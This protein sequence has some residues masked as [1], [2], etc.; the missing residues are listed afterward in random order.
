MDSL[1]VFGS[2][3]G[4]TLGGPRLASDIDDAIPRSYGLTANFPKRPRAAKA[5][6]NPEALFGALPKTPTRAPVLWAHQ[7]DQLRSYFNQHGD[8]PDVALELPTGSGKT[9]V[10]LLIADWRRRAKDHRTVYAC[11][12]VQLAEQVHKSA[13]QQGIETTLLVGTRSQWDSA[14]LASYT[15]AVSVVVTTYSHV[16]N[17]YSAFSDVQ[18]LVFDDAHAAE[19]YVA[20]SWS[21]TVPRSHALYRML[22]EILRDDV[23]GMFVD[24]MINKTDE[25]PHDPEIRVMPMS[26]LI[27]KRSELVRVLQEAA[28][29]KKETLRYDIL[30]LLPS[31]QSCLFYINQKE[32]YIRPYIPPTFDHAPFVE[33]TQRVYL[34]ATLGNG[35][36]LERA[37]GRPKVARIGVP[38]QWEQ[39]GSG[40]RF[41]VF[42][43]LVEN[44]SFG[45]ARSVEDKAVEGEAE[46]VEPS[47][48]ERILN[49]SDKRVV[50]A[51]DGPT[52]ERVAKVLKVPSDQLFRVSDKQFK[53]F[54]DA[55][56]G[57]LLAANRY[58]GMDLAND[59]C[60]MM[61]M[62]GLPS[63]SHLQ[64]RFLES[65]LRA[66]DVLLE[67]VRTR[68]IQGLGRC[69]RGPQDYSVVVVEGEQL[70][71]FLS[72]RENRSAMPVDLQAEIEYGLYTS[73][74]VDAETLLALT[75]S[76][77]RQ[78]ATWQT[79][80]E[81]EIIEWR[82]ELET[83]LPAASQKL[84]S[85]A[86]KEV[87]AWRASW[88]EQ[89][90]KA[91]QLAME[92]HEGLNGTEL[93]AYRS[94]WAYLAFSW[95]TLAASAGSPTLE[96]A[97]EYWKLAE[98]ASV[99]T[100][101]LKEIQRTAVTAPTLEPWDE[102]AVKK[103]HELAQQ[104]KPAKLSAVLGGMVAD[105]ANKKADIYERGL[106][107]AGTLLGARA[108]KPEGEARADSVWL[109]DN[110]WLTL[111]AKSEQLEGGT[112]DRTYVRQANTQLASL[113]HDEGTEDAPEMSVSLI[114]SP[115][116]AVKPDAVHMAAAHL[117][118]FPVDDMLALAQ[119]IRRAWAQI[120][121]FATDSE[122]DEQQAS[123]AACLWEWKLL[124]SQVR[125]R[126]TV[127]PIK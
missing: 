120:R 108:F 50:L 3:V 78:D 80:A 70:V 45:E 83:E 66:R 122:D 59:A 17:R 109:W 77:L 67:R 117:Y 119:D 61:L 114:L 76:A 58:D 44:S 53:D 107:T 88:S 39:S 21:L 121:T 11:P 74:S 126:M 24:R 99:G 15:R 93:T 34:S 1:H 56:K 28:E 100:T 90:D 102:S 97:N 86:A 10:G 116:K 52:T 35:G 62:Q 6:A 14:H 31:L 106:T 55:P 68:V 60:R 118:L 47:L 26:A 124:P 63:T 40:R 72:R 103:I 2:F 85:T 96:K 98:A 95:L 101:W 48:T 5:P 64:D 123:L 110:L 43:S 91:A 92:V 13:R 57:T 112:I 9:L 81:P 105:L 46:T 37:F 23:D 22:L 12:T 51:Q 42:P 73:A 69:T 38:E 75:A 54:L 87:Q 49:L 94:L 104:T 27:H 7:A 33:A 65:K 16:F 113:A 115:K 20:E 111:E 4:S 8:A 25:S 82:Q 36:E 18:S 79:Q 125:Q 41:F 127:D 30:R 19:S 89:W 29:D 32:W 71:R 84:A